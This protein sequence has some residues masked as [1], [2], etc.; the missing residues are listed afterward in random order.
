[1]NEKCN[2]TKRTY[3]TKW[4]RYCTVIG[5]I[6]VALGGLFM[7]LY[8]V[9]ALMEQNAPT[10]FLLATYFSLSI[11]FQFIYSLISVG[12]GALILVITAKNNPHMKETQTWMVVA[13]LLGII[14]GTLGGLMILGGVL[15]YF[16]V[17]II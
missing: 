11:E 13:F 5:V 14:G 15:I 16:I 4:H 9:V 12:T 3:K 6:I 1:M 10:P 8:G 7:L 17:A 2:M